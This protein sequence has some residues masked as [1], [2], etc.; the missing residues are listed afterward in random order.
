MSLFRVSFGLFVE[1]NYILVYLEELF[2]V[3]PL[4]RASQ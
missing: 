1:T 2:I 3:F 4:L